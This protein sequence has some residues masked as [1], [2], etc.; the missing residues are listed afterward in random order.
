M[1]DS[2]A[3]RSSSAGM[4][5]AMFSIGSISGGSATIR[6]VPSAT[7]ASFE[8]AWRLSRVRAFSS[9]R[10]AVR[11]DRFDASRRRSATCVSISSRAYQTSSVRMAAK[12]RIDTR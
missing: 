1:T 12:A 10:T 11:T 2:S 5:P 8:N 7:V 6:G 3:D 9:V 4:P